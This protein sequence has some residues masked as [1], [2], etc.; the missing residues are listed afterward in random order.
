MFD[1][2]DMTFAMTTE[3]SAYSSPLPEA[4][5]CL[6]CGLCASA[7]PTFKLFASQEET[8]RSRV[9]TLRNILFD[10]QRISATEREHLD[11]CLQCRACETVCPSK[12]SYGTQ[13]DHAQAQLTQQPSLRAKL[14]LAFIAHKTWRTKL[15]PC[16]AFYLHSG[17]QPLIRR[18]GLLK[19]LGLAEA[20]ALLTQPTLKPLATHYPSTH[21]K[22][23][24]VALFTG[25]ITEHFD[26]ASL[27]AAIQL[28]NAMGYA[29]IVP[30]TQT[31]CGAIHQHNGFNA[32]TLIENNIAIFNALNV[33]AVV[34]TA[35]GCG[36]ML[37]EY[38]IEKTSAADKFKQR[39]HD[40]LDFLLEHWPDDL[41]LKPLAEK[42][43]IHEPCSQRNVLKNQ[44][45]VY[46]L[47]AKI[48]ALEMLELADNALCCGAAGS[49][50]LTHPENARQ[51]YEL[52]Q[53]A[54][55]TATV[56][57]VVS[58]NYACAAFLNTRHCSVTHPLQLLAQQLDNP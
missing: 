56:T 23:G 6:S 34:F 48:P 57:R 49:Y 43:A 20:E 39:L 47:L 36:A 19:K 13:F 25:C 16:L 4:A 22:L 51:L 58:S 3:D 32:S 10:K 9:R 41:V 52:K 18:S 8:P 42:I 40:I 30:S 17:L 55:K 24:Q 5:D 53:H 50:Q 54:I 29:V 7:C 37:S 27:Q 28:L 21:R 46:E 2:A 15:M 26:R 33:D 14:A 35:T 44:Q 11:N 38:T 1:P 12:M 45:T 31:C